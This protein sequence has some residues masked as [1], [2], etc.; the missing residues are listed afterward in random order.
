VRDTSGSTPNP[1][2]LKGKKGG[3]DRL[4]KNNF[5]VKVYISSIPKDIICMRFYKEKGIFYRVSK[6]MSSCRGE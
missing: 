4:T 6:L 1:K 2:T 3:K 5:F